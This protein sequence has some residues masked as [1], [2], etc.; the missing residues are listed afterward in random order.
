M[1]NTMYDFALNIIPMGSEYLI[2]AACLVAGE[3]HVQSLSR[4]DIIE[5]SLIGQQLASSC[6]DVPAALYTIG[7]R[8]FQ[9]V[10][11]EERLELFMRA[12][13]VAYEQR[14]SLRVLIKY[15]HAPELH[16]IPWELLHDGQ[17][18]LVTNPTTPVVRYL[19]QQRPLESL[20]IEPPLRVLFSTAS[21]KGEAPLDVVA[22]EQSLRVAVAG[23]GGAFDLV[24]EH[25]LSFDRL[26]Q[27]L[28]RE[29]RRG[30]PIHI[31]HHFGHGSL[32]ERDGAIAF[33]LVLDDAGDRHRVTVAQIS[34]LIQACPSL[35]AVVLSVCHGGVADG[36]APS[37]AS[38]NVPAVI[39]FRG[40]LPI[41][42]SRIFART[43]Y[44]ALLHTPLDVALG[45]ARLALATAASRTADWAL[46]LL[47][48]RTTHPMLLPKAEPAPVPPQV[49]A[50]GGPIIRFGGTIRSEQTVR[51]GQ[52][53]IGDRP[54]ALQSDMTIAFEP[55]ALETKSLLEIGGLSISAEEAASRFSDLRRLAQA[56]APRDA[57]SEDSNRS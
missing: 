53:N 20:A 17:R 2:H 9:K 26:Q 39:G 57:D 14:S 45:Q 22:E 25:A 29:Q 32:R 16:E 48:L 8:L 36:L 55:T 24:I 43:F 19:E 5:F 46:P 42:S 15:T 47:F 34:T 31:W 1:S 3:S 33:N 4:A 37:L 54:P 13:A 52:V 28:L 21:P 30:R 18:Y 40:A 41:E 35:R 56:L 27:V 50:G 38:L 11:S 12:Q 10:F 23:F 7:R 44:G 6:I 51:I 49:S